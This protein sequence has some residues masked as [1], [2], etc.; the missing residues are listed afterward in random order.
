MDVWE[1]SGKFPARRPER[2]SDLRYSV[3]ED[4]IV[5]FVGHGAPQEAHLVDLSQD[6]C[7]LR[8]TEPITARSRLPVEVFFTIEGISFRFRSVLQWTDGHNLVGIR[9][10]NTMPQRLVE[11]ASVI[12]KMEKNAAARAD[13]VNLLIAKHKAEQ[14][15]G[16]QATMR[17]DAPGQVG[18]PGH[19]GERGRVP[20][21]GKLTKLL[22]FAPL[23]Q[24]EALQPATGRERRGHAR[25]ELDT[26]AMILLPNV[27]S[28]LHGRI[29]DLSL[30][31]SR[32]RT[33]E[34]FPASINTRVETDFRP[35]GLP[36]RLGGVI[37]AI[38]ERNIVGIRFLDINEQKR[39]QVSSLIG[40][41]ERSQ[42][43]LPD[44]PEGRM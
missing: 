26:T 34:R 3:D 41:I 28:P 18:D 25:H 31:G 16:H 22:D 24:G 36:F 21:A 9:F 30:T 39:E 32:V 44:A 6:G 38:H 10:V 43:E 11:L 7:R 12:C 13:V 4:S 23:P 15:T 2:R 14:S 40:E 35:Q 1:E 29:L 19:V 5:L 37:Q 33:D 20:V 42:A 8:T 27:E 17:A